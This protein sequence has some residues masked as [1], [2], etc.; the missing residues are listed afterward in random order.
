MEEKEDTALLSQL[1]KSIEEIEPI[2]DK[3]YKTQ[4][5]NTFNKSKKLIIQIQKEIL[6]TIK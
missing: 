5:S 3:A 1:V 4:D 6:K 2:L